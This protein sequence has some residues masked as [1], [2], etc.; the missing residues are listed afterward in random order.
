ML[1]VI[2]RNIRGNFLIPGGI[3][4]ETGLDETLPKTDNSL[5]G[6]IVNYPDTKMASFPVRIWV[7]G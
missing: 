7:K 2:S 5:S 3:P 1:H 6:W 4:P